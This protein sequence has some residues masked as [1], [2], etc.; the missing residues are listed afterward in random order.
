LSPLNAKEP[1]LGA[2]TKKID[3]GQTG[4]VAE[5]PAINPRDVL[6]NCDVG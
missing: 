6:W 3:T 5:S 1:M 2:F 4:A